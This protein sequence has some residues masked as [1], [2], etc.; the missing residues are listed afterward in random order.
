[1]DINQLGDEIRKD[2]RITELWIVVAAISLGFA[3]GVFA[4]RVIGG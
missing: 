3:V 4:C 1:M 2:I